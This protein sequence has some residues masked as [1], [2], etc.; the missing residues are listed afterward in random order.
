VRLEQRG[1]LMVVAVASTVLLTA[2]KEPSTRIRIFFGV[3]SLR[4]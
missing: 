3:R 1:E 4:I 2:G